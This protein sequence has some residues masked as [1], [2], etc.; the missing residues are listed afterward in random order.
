MS[1]YVTRLNVL[2]AVVCKPEL[3]CF[4]N[5]SIEF[6]G[7][8]LSYTIGS[9]VGMCLVLMGTRSDRRL[10]SLGGCE[11]LA[12][13]R[14]R[15]L[16]ANNP[17]VTISGENQKWE[18]SVVAQTHKLDDHKTGT[19]GSAGSGWNG[20]EPQQ[21]RDHT[22]HCFPKSKE[23]NEYVTGCSMLRSCRVLMDSQ[24]SLVSHKK[25]SALKVRDHTLC[26][27]PNGYPR[28]CPCHFDSLTPPTSTP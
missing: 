28:T 15:G 22:L 19:Q 14:R 6:I 11:S 8:L 21:A 27:W 16:W 3:D 13:T 17:R 10:G 23:Q 24:P 5:G 1:Q 18:W 7:E 26:V 2:C 12:A 4:S 25:E 9:M 20:Y